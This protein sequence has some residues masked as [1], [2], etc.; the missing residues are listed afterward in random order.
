LAM[1]LALVN[2]PEILF[3][4]ELTTGLD[5]QARRNV[6]DIIERLKGRGETIILTTHYMEEA[7][8]LCHRVGIMDYGRIIALDTAGDMIARQNLES[9]VEFITSNGVSKEFFQKLPR[10]SRVTQDEDRFILHTKEASTV[11]MELTRLS[12]IDGLN[13]ESISVRNATLEDVFLEMT[14]RKLRE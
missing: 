8:R 10:V 6:W 4:D 14:G 5:P 3:L 9:A 7:E 11:L 2:A 12:E 13:L 1:A